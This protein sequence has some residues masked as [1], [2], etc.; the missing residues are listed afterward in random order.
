[1]CPI[2]VRSPC[3]LTLRGF[4]WERGISSFR[5]LRDLVPRLGVN[6]PPD[7]PREP[8]YTL[9]RDIQHPAC[10]TFSVPSIALHSGSGLLTRFPSATAF[11]LTLG[12]DSPCADE[13]CA[14]NLGLSA[15]MPFTCFIAT[16]VSIRTSD[17]SSELDN[18]PSQAYGTLSYR[19]RGQKTEDRGQIQTCPLP[20]F[21]LLFPA[22]GQALQHF[23]DVLIFVAPMLPCLLV[24]I[25]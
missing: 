21:L 22:F 17:T 23:C 2:T 10:L 8:T 9:H 20:P 16:H 5:L 13:R 3:N 12:A 25:A 15:S 18:P 24:Y 19:I 11:A 14:G 6:D 1:M 4:S 7:L